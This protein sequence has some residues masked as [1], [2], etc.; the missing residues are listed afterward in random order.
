M[1]VSNT[2]PHSHAASTTNGEPMLSPPRHG[3]GTAIIQPAPWSGSRPWLDERL[4]RR[5]QLVGISRVGRAERAE[6]VVAHHL[7]PLRPQQECDELFGG[8]FF[9]AAG[10][11]GDRVND[12]LAGE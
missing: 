11:D 9:R 6:P 8:G 4:E 7:A 12:R 10:D 2:P 1:K 5:R 3:R